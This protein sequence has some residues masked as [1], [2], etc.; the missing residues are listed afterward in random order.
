MAARMWVWSKR[1]ALRQEDLWEERF[2]GNQNAVITRL[3]SGKFLRV[4]LYCEEEGEALELVE[5]FGGV[6]RSLT[7]VDWV[8]ESAKPLP[9]L[10][11]RDC[12]LVT[13][14]TNVARLHEL[15][16]NNEGRTV[17][18]I[19]AEM[20]FG[21]GDHA[22]TSSCL[23][24]LADEAR[25]RRGEGWSMLDLGCGTGVLAIAASLL[26][27]NECE[28]MDI[29]PNA[30]SVA[31]RNVERNNAPGVLVSCA[32]L[33]DWIPGTSY[34]VVVANLF[35]A[36]LQRSFE[37]IGEALKAGG[38]LIL[39][40]ILQDQWDDTEKAAQAAGLAFEVV[41]RRGKWIAAKGGFA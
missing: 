19:P 27:A 31:R 36:V 28:A 25:R 30:V 34:D 14:E 16:E 2:H 22:T 41:H 40:G 15:Q 13:S 26:G 32:D 3:R 33:E 38:I 6:V 35:A 37:K 23:R 8:A 18:I 12:L 17:V 5:Q 39:S 24:F 9:P 29:D 11:I 4:D 10:K 1:S 20:A 21:T 7:E